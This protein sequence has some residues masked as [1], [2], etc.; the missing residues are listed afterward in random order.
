MGWR[1]APGMMSEQETGTLGIGLV[2]LGWPGEQHAKAIQA[3]PGVRLEAACDSSKE[4]RETFAQTFAPGK[5]YVA[6]DDLLADPAVKAVIVSLPNFLHASATLAALRAGKHVLCEKPPTMDVAEIEAIREEANKRG[7]VYAFSRQSRFSSKMLA[8]KRLV[9]AGDLGNIY[10]VKAERVR[11]RGIPVGV[12]GW[13][14][15]KSK[16]GGGAMIDIGVHAIDAAWYLLGCPEPL[17]VS[18]RVSVN[19]GHLIPAGVKC[20]VEDAGFAFIR[21]AGDVV[22]HLEVAWAANV[23]DMVP[24]ST[25]AGHEVE[26]TTLYGTAA[27]LQLDPLTLFTMEGMQRKDAVLDSEVDSGA[28]VR[29]MDDFT[30]AIKEGRLPINDAD[31]AVTLMKLLGAIYESS[32]KGSEIRLTG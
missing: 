4:R 9:N 16:A 28:F 18:A 10:F 29:Q 1:T 24:A 32:R 21:F 23:T 19:F 22:M 25:W 15:E 14:L 3:L 27:T 26:N 5:M 8:A 7:L 6:Y 13:F 11:S 2:G 31:R 30:G 17:T 20:D 12:G